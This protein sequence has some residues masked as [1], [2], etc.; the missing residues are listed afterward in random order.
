[1]NEIKRLDK[2]GVY[3][4]EREISGIEYRLIEGLRSK[5][6]RKRIREG[7]GIEIIMKRGE[8]RQIEKE[9]KG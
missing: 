1:M 9:T 4:T 3:G 5:E 7:I 8:I 2:R 6:E